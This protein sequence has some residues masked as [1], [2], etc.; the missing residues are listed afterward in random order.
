MTKLTQVQATYLAN[1]AAGRHPSE[2]LDGRALMHV[3]GALE[4]KGLVRWVNEDEYRLR[5]ELTDLGQQY[6]ETASVQRMA[7][8]GTT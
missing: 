3:R 5:L 4:R 8:G 2:G 1:M 7:K 6:A